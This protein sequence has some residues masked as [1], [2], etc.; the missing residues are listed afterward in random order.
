[1]ENATETTAAST[2]VEEPS[3]ENWKCAPAN[4]A[5][6]ADAMNKAFDYR[7]D[8]TLTLKDGTQRVGYV[9]NRNADVPEPFIEMFPSDKDE[10]VKLFY[11]D[12]AAVHFTGKDTAAGNSWAAFVASREKKE[13]ADKKDRV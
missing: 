1:M 6:L 8:I 10:R 12:V 2:P 5:E 7:G 11:K 13:A 9:F 3:L 4:Q